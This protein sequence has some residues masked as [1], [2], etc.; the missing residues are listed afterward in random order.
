VSTV[1]ALIG[2]AASLG[3]AAASVG[4]LLVQH[5]TER[6]RLQLVERLAARHGV[7]AVS[8]LG[9]LIPPEIP[10]E[11]RSARPQRRSSTT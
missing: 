1:F 4:R 10:N 2:F 5:R 8:A 6:Q 11:P 9:R 3:T 7:E